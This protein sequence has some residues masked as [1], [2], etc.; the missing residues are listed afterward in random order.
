VVRHRR[1]TLTLLLL[2]SWVTGACG[3]FE[4]DA[5]GPATTVDL[6]PPPPTVAQPDTAAPPGTL[7]FAEPAGDAPAGGT[8]WRIAYWSTGAEGE[9][10]VVTGQVY[11]PPGAPPPGGW[12]VVAWAHPTVGTSDRCTPS[13]QGSRSLHLVE[14]LTRAGIAVAATDYEGLGT[15]GSHPY[16]VGPASGYDV[17]DSVRAASVI[18]GSGVPVEARV[19]IGGFSQGGH[20]ALWA[21]QVAAE[22]APEIEVL[23]VF[24]AAPV[25]SVVAFAERAHKA[26]PDQVGVLVTIAA[27]MSQVDPDLD[28]ADILTDEAFDRLDI[29]EDYCIGEAVAGFGR[30]D[31][32]SGVFVASPLDVPAWRKQLEAHGAGQVP[33]GVPVRIVQGDQ[34]LIVFEQITRA[35]VDVMCAQGD[36]VEYE[37]VA[38]A[39]HALLTPERAVPWIQGR[40]SGETA[41]DTCP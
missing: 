35:T 20:A 27:G 6:G 22:Y 32:E 31:R 29:L 10:V 25:T 39:D 21:A 14:E 40:I 36:V 38:G 19:V 13:M 5:A 30:I 41:P 9:A 11:V 34:D 28:L 24:A 18:E 17:L 12:P 37:V 1:V 33:L 26:G 4:D 3:A 8:G 23:G 15:E 7:V 16:L 2:V